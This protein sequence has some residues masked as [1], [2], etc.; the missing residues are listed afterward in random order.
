MTYEQF[1]QTEFYKTTFEYMLT[2][3]SEEFTTR[4]LKDLYF[5]KETAGTLETIKDFCDCDLTE[6]DE[7][8]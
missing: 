6:T 8:F 1:K 5:R 3:Y 7:A 2:K 4:T